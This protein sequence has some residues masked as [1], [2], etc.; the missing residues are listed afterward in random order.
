[1]GFGVLTATSGGRDV[2]S[3]GERLAA[4]GIG[5]AFVERDDASREQPAS[6]D[7]TGRTPAPWPEFH[8][9]WM[10][11]V[12]GVVCAV[13]V[14]LLR[15]DPF[16]NPDSYAF[17]ALARSLL[18]GH[19][20][21][22]REPMFPSVPLY[23]FRSPGYAAFLALALMLGG[24]TAAVTLQERCRGSRPRS[25]AIS[26]DSSPAGAPPGSRSRCGSPGSRPGRTRGSSRPSRS[27]SSR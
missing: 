21:V 9:G 4:T 7:A 1:M 2:R 15:V 17:V 18:A 3:V 26:R 20:L 27:S 14:H 12:A 8:V 10:C 19:G 13:A 5:R 25:S 24:V 23:A 11:A 22:Y 6:L 16:Q